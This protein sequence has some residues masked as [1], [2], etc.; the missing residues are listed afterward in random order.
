MKLARISVEVWNNPNGFHTYL[1][2]Y[3]TNPVIEQIV[4]LYPHKVG[5]SLYKDNNHQP[6]KQG[7]HH[8]VR[9]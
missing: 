1:R 7:I 3:Y 2:R 8:R 5:T 4:G 6:I 9:P